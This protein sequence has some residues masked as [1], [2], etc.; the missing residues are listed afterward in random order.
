MAA[1]KKAIRAQAFK[2]QEIVGLVERSNSE[3]IS[4]EQPVDGKTCQQGEALHRRTPTRSS[5]VGV[6]RWSVSPC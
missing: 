6:L 4:L 1:R 5:D 2:H 3:V